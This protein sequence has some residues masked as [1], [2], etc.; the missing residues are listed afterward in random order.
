MET[1]ELFVP[2]TSLQVT[3]SWWLGFGVQPW[4]SLGWEAI[5]APK[6]ADFGS[7]A[8]THS[9][10]I[11]VLFGEDIHREKGIRAVLFPCF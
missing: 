1:E 9:L 5:Q 8:W 7:T 11:G 3:L 6:A 2:P 4:L 10:G